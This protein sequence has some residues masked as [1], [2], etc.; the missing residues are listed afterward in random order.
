MNS[1]RV[2]DQCQVAYDRS[3]R[4]WLAVNGHV[5]ARVPA[6][7]DG[8]NQAVEAAI[9]DQ[10]PALAAAVEKLLAN[11]PENEALRRRAWRA[12][13]MVANGDVE[14]VQDKPP[15]VAKVESQSKRNTAY[16]ISRIAVN[17]SY[18]W[19]NTYYSLACTCADYRDGRAPVVKGHFLCKHVLALHL[20][21]RLE[22]AS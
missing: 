16:W 2:G 9:R 4:Q 13:Q 7:P 15:S 14:F 3:T 21:H 1:Y 6:G 17:S 5:I 8:K 18:Q 20:A 12:A 10:Y 11:E 22:K 19:R